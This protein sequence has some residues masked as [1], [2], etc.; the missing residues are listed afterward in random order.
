MESDPNTDRSVMANM[1][2]VIILTLELSASPVLCDVL[3]RAEGFLARHTCR[4][5]Y[6]SEVFVF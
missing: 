2:C 3:L 6:T 4:V 5:R 1:F